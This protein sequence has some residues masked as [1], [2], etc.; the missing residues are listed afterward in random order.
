MKEIVIVIGVLAGLFFIGV[1]VFN[2]YAP[3]AFCFGYLLLVC[4]VFCG[5]EVFEIEEENYDG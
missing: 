3:Y 4:S 5:V 1:A 2:M